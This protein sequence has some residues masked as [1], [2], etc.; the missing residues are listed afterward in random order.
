M[1]EVIQRVLAV[2]AL[3]ELPWIIIIAFAF[4]LLMTG[5]ILGVI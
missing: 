3:T 2:S 5:A 4:G 1:A